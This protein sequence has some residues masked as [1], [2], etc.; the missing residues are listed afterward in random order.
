MS[1]AVH[2]KKQDFQPILNFTFVTVKFVDVSCM[3]SV[4]LLM[5]RKRGCCES[6]YFNGSGNF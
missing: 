2:S 6:V 1:R 4:I 3:L 5:Q